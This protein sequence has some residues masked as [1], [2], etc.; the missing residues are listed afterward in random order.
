MNRSIY[1]WLV[2]ASL[3]LVTDVGTVAANQGLVEENSDTARIAQL[4]S[5]WEKEG[6]EGAR[7]L[8]REL[9]ALTAS[10]RRPIMQALSRM[11]SAEAQRVLLEVA[12]GSLGSEAEFSGAVYYLAAINSES[13]ARR[14]F[15]SEDPKVWC[16]A[17]RTLWKRQSS[18]DAE[19]LADVGRMLGSE[20][21]EVRQNCARLLSLDPSVELGREK[22]LALIMSIETVSRLPRSNEPAGHTHEYGRPWTVAGLVYE[23]IIEALGGARCIDAAL[24]KEATPESSGLAR[25]CVLIAR[26]QRQDATV[27]TELYRI[28]RESPVGKIRFA[29]VDA[30]CRPDYGR[31]EDLPELELVAAEDPLSTTLVDGQS[32]PLGREDWLQPGHPPPEAFPIR[33]HAREAIQRIRQQ[34][35]L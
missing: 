35:G 33:H 5:T 9:P 8:G 20:D 10:Q 31:P 13:D 18:V 11:K 29:A 1:R 12:C 14:L 24:L 16:V 19:L 30:F 27:R 2:A 21:L 23:D 26:A 28:M 25:D 32:I 17:L 15:A 22:A 34:S 3:V 6:D 4:V 7:H